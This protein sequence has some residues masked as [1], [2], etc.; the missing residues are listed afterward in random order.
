MFPLPHVIF[1]TIFCI[2][3]YPFIGINVL[4]VWTAS[5]FID[6]DHYL[7]YIL[8]EKSWN[9]ANAYKRYKLKEFRYLNY[10]FH[11][12]HLIEL[13]ILIGLLSF[14]NKILFYIFIGMLFHYILDWVDL[15]LRYNE[16]K[17]ERTW[18]LLMYFKRKWN[19]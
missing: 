17:K 5:I 7:W 10:K 4:I 3:L 12:F 16:V 11:I 1:S 9:L 18:S 14:Y 8:N 2:I 6:V 15:F 19:T 13:L